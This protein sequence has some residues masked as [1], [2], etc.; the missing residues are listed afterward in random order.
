MF[1]VEFADIETGGRLVVFLFLI[2]M[3]IIMRFDLVI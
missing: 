2:I 1:F 3:L